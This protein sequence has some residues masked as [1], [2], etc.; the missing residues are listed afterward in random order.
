MSGERSQFLKINLG[1]YGYSMFQILKL[2]N[3]LFYFFFYK[4]SFVLLIS[5]FIYQ[6]NIDMFYILWFPFAIS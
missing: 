2:T 4:K 6:L 3:V 1:T 5:T